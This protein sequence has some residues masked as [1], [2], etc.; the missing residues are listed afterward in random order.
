M[1]VTPLRKFKRLVLVSGSP[2]AV[3]CGEG[4]GRLRTGRPRAVSKK[5]KAPPRGKAELPGR[6]KA[7]GGIDLLQGYVGG[8]RKKVQNESAAWAEY[9]RPA[10]LPWKLDTQRPST[11]VS[12]PPGKSS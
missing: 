11:D 1:V 8:S 5:P 2:I 10:A 9:V 6:S 4:Q 3:K 12:A 7:I